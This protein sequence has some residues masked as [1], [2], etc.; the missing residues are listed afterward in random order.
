MP[1]R[2]PQKY[3]NEEERKA[4]NQAC[5]QKHQQKKKD[6]ANMQTQFDGLGRPDTAEKTSERLGVRVKEMNIPT[7]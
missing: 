4:G 1:H 5:V 3:A 2:C 6:E 7:G